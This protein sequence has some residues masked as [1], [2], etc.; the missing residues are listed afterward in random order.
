MIQFNLLPDVKLEYIKA[1]RSKR[2]VLLAAVGV[3]GAALTIF[4][5][6]FLIVNVYQKQRLNSLNNDIKKNTATLQGIPDLAKILTVQNQ[7]NS[8][9]GLHAQ[10]P[11]T[12]RLFGYLGQVTPAN[13]TISDL[14]ADFQ[15]NTLDITGNADAISTVNQYVDT[16]KF[17]T[18]RVDGGEADTKAFSEVVLT[19]FGRNDKGA[20]YQISLKFDPVIFDNTKQVELVVPKIISTRSETEKPSDLFQKNTNQVTQ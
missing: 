11:A 9:S 17:T 6:L 18:Y 15:D 14:K 7:L 2:M 1:K 19:S 4:V 10:D 5:I 3:A 20:T 8:L 13:V 16:L 12:S